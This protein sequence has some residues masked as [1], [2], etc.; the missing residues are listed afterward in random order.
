MRALYDGHEQGRRRRPRRSSRC[1]TSRPDRLRPVTGAPARRVV[2]SRQR[3]R[4]RVRF[5]TGGRVPRLAGR[6]HERRGGIGPGR[7]ADPKA[8]RQPDRPEPTVQSGWKK[9]GCVNGPAGPCIVRRPPRSRS[10]SDGDGASDYD[11]RARDDRRPG[12]RAS[13]APASASTASRSPSTARG[14][15]RPRRLDLDVRPGEVVAIIGPNGCGKSTLLRVLAGLIAPGRGGG[16]H[17]RRPGRRAGRAGGA[18]VPG[19]AAARRGDRRR[20]NI[21]FP[22]ELAGWPRDRQRERA[23]ELLRLV[24]LARG[25]GGQA[26][27]ALRRHAPAG[28]DRPGAR[29]RARGAA[30]RRAVQRP[31][32]PDPRAAQRRAPGAL[33]PVERHDRA[34]HPL[35][36]RGG[37]PRRPRDRAVAAPGARG[38][39]R[40]G[41]LPRPRRLADLD[42]AFVSAVAAEVRAHLAERWTRRPRDR[43]PRRDP[44]P[45]PGRRRGR[46]PRA[47]GPRT[48]AA[49]R[50]ARV[51]RG[52]EP[53]RVPPPVAARGRG[54]RAS[55]RSSCPAR[56]RSPSDSSA[57]GPR[58]TMWPHVAADAGR[59]PAGL[60]HR[61]DARGH[62]RRRCS[63]ARGSWSGC[64]AR[65]SSRPRRRPSSRSPRSS[66][67]GS[68]TASRRSS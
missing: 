25:R 45:R 15:P 29:A 40:P 41:R 33:G 61:G 14:P 12:V 1:S 23:A 22:L 46:P 67:C 49:A 2:Q 48:P 64:S 56:T 66:S 38:R 21:R 57:P 7:A 4:G 26:V 60:R 50:S 31:R 30:A 27:D 28:R 65:T 36:P 20:Q 16:R 42:S 6:A 17:R 62:G 37:V 5:P 18:R 51:A 59:D 43:D 35:H 68:A 39:R 55:S 54:S 11:E 24:G 53:R 44:S 8:R 34:R 47:R 10:D 9:A 3:L 58:G 19:A 63:P 52:R 32:R 13:P